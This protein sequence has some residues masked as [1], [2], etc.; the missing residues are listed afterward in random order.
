MIYIVFLIRW[1]VLICLFYV[2]CSFFG[3]NPPCCDSL[4]VSVDIGVAL[5]VFSMV[6]DIFWMMW[7]ICKH[8]DCH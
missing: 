3:K 5:H 4:L 6:S 1:F 7:S 8:A 2:F